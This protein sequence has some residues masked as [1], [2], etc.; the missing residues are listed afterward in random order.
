MPSKMMVSV[1]STELPA[2]LTAGPS[3]VLHRL[4]ISSSSN[5]IALATIRHLRPQRKVPGNF[6][7]G[8]NHQ[9]TGQNRPLSLDCSGLP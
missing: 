8:R 6:K 2:I 7:H 9:Q 5:E 1:R 4:C 3:H